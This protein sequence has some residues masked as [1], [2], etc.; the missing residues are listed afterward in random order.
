MI[1]RRSVKRN[2]CILGIFFLNVSLPSSPSRTRCVSSPFLMSH[3]AIEMIGTALTST[4]KYSCRLIIRI[5]SMR[6]IFRA[7]SLQFFTICNGKRM[8]C[9]QQ[10][11]FLNKQEKKLCVCVCVCV[12]VCLCV[13]V[14]THTDRL[15]ISRW[16]P[17]LLNFSWEMWTAEP[18]CLTPVVSFFR[19]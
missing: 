13:C 9:W 11:A 4:G 7:S 17:G 8:W 19:S 15:Q 2:M 16:L 12:C 18:Y 5:S 3:R 14:S 6:S 1:T 10:N